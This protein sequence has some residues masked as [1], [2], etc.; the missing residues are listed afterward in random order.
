M[1]PNA[2]AFIRGAL[3]VF[4]VTGEERKE[5]AVEYGSHAVIRMAFAIDAGCPV[6]SLFCIS[7]VEQA[8]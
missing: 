6:A 3:H 5:I 4:A 7:D 8:D 2:P 1:F